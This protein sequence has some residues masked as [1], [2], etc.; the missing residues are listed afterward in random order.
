LDELG[1]LAGTYAR[2]EDKSSGPI[3]RARKVLKR[4]G[5]SSVYGARWTKGSGSFAPRCFPPL[6][7]QVM[8]EIER[9]TGIAFC[10]FGAVLGAA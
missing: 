3:N 7:A 10:H 8:G 5:A 9:K 2:C 4:V 1:T 6:L